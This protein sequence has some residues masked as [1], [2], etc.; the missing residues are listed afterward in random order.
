MTP[1]E[2]KRWLTA[3]LREI[4]PHIG[5]PPTPVF[6]ETV[7]TAKAYAYLLGLHDFALSLPDSELGKTPLTAANQL[8][9]CIKALEAPA[10]STDERDT[11][12]P[13]EV[14]KL[15]KVSPDKVLGW[16]RD[17]QLKASNLS[18][19]HRPRWAVSKADLELF[20]KTKQP[21]PP[22]TPKKKSVLRPGAVRRY[23]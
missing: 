4:E 7:A 9:R 20:L 10:V 11:F 21:E 17:K 23:S 12:T 6:A 5:E 18:N 14:A 19:G 3:Q 13:P 22:V 2:F 1:T 15:L 8:K 16:I